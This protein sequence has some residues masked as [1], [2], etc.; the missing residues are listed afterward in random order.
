M[1]RFAVAILLLVSAGCLVAQTE[2]FDLVTYTPPEDWAKE[3]AANSISY[4][5]VNKKSN[6]WCQIRILKSTI[7]KGGIEVDFESEWQE[8]IVKNYK[9]TE[10]RQL[11]EV[12]ESGGWKI[13][14]GVVKFTF[15]NSDGL[16]KLTT[17]SGFQRCASIIAITNSQDY[18]RDI[19][20]F[21]STIVLENLNTKSG[22]VDRDLANAPVQASHSTS[23]VVGT[24]GISVVVPYRSGTEGTAGSTLK[25]YTFNTDGTF[26]FYSKTF[27]YKYPNLLLIREQGTY[28][29]NGNT[30]TLNP[31]KSV[32]ESWSKKDGTDNWG[33]ILTTENRTLEKIAYQFTKDYSSGLQQWN[34][35][36][37][38]NAATK[39]DGPFMNSS[40]FT[41][42]W[43]YSD[44]PAN[45]VIELPDQ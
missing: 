13:R 21:L 1:K 45:S 29:I 19:E 37:Q 9:P 28:Q 8:L 5:A 27:K 22:G 18:L 17:F 42:A 15:N 26:T 6:T 44:I 14:T 10:L 7:S 40:Y 24:W 41:N 20:A 31:Q 4:T 16:A 38:A 39:R 43:L 35:V 30:I 2:T 32:I 12:Q 33:K 25:Q 36:L 3:V 11:N 34:L 23:S